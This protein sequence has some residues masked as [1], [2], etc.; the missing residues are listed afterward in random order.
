[1][2]VD[3]SQ[4]NVAVVPMII[5]G[6]GV[7]VMLM[8][9]GRAPQPKNANKGTAIRTPVSSLIIILFF[10]FIA[11]IFYTTSYVIASHFP[12]EPLDRCRAEKVP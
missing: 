12:Y 9:G 10:G 3:A 7:I 4:D 11:K 1:M 8:L 2:L 5:G 6:A